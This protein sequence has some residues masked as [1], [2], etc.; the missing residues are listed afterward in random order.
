MT[1]NQKMNLRSTIKA[2][3]N[4]QN[5]LLCKIAEDVGFEGVFSRTQINFEDPRINPSD[6][7][8][9]DIVSKKLYN[10]TWELDKLEQPEVHQA[11]QFTY[12]LMNLLPLEDAV[13]LLRDAGCNSTLDLVEKLTIKPD[14]MKELVL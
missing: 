13:A 5:R 11:R 6:K 8:K 3:T 4:T 1:E 7:K 14:L 12:D 2:L 10:A 9:F